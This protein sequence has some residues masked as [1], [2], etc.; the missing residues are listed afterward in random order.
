[1][2]NTRI[3]L[4]FCLFTIFFSIAVLP[5]AAFNVFD[6]RVIEYLEIPDSVFPEDESI[7][8]VGQL[9]LIKGLPHQ[10]ELAEGL[11]IRIQPP[12]ESAGGASAFAVYVF[13]GV[14][15]R[16]GSPVSNTVEIGEVGSFQGQRIL[17]E[18]LP[19]RGTFSIRIPGRNE[20]TIRGGIDSRVTH[21]VSQEN[22]VVAITIQPIMK[23]L[24]RDVLNAPFSITALPLLTSRGGLHISVLS[25]N[26]EVLTADEMQDRN[27]SLELDRFGT[28][29]PNETI[30]IQ[31]GIYQIL[32]K[33]GDILYASAQA[34]VEQG[35]VEHAR[36]T[37]PRPESQIT[38]E[39][40]NE[41]IVFIDGQAIEEDR[42]TL[43]PGEY[44][45]Q[46]RLGSYQQEHKI[47]VQAG[48][49]Y[50]VGLELGVNIDSQGENRQNTE[51][52]HN[53]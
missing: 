40:P 49:Q 53:E 30:Y 6:G 13:S 11:E 19:P 39:L 52:L 14:Q 29:E 36:I 28:M 32:V 51:I 18:I 33:H 48:R 35:S 46:L 47:S 26:G 9:L 27:L 4:I 3:P 31:P 34:G 2:I 20:H 1:M 23:G 25:H 15:E 43:P 7:L 41:V 50:T 37:L 22:N 16:D 45:I 17:M 24:P 38:F 42:I 21:A 5:L 10:S 12:A 44:T 8:R